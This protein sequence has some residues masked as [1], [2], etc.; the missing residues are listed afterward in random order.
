MGFWKELVSGKED[1]SSKRVAGLSL[2]SMYIAI[3]ILAA[4]GGN[5]PVEV[6]S[7]AKLGLYTGATLL[8]ISVAPEMLKVVQRPPETFIVDETEKK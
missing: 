4:A 2:I 6:E 5:L 1:V 3:T 7:L 8:G